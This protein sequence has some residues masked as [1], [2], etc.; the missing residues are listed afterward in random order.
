MVIKSGG[1]A[2]GCIL[3]GGVVGT[4]KELPNKF[5]FLKN[6]ILNC[7]RLGKVPRRHQLRGPFGQMLMEEM[8]KSDLTKKVGKD[9]FVSTY[10]PISICIH[11]YFYPY[12]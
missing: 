3:K 7:S 11:I 12:I 8:A 4:S 9:V 5:F 1:L 6:N 2:K 10:L